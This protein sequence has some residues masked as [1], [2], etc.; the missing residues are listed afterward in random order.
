MRKI[1]LIASAFFP[2]DVTDDVPAMT[3]GGDVAVV[4][5]EVTVES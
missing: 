5:A 1:V 4:G 2:P 3:E